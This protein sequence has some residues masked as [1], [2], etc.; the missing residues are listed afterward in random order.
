M[1]AARLAAGVRSRAGLTCPLTALEKWLLEVGGRVLYESSY[2]SHYLHD[3]LCPAW[4]RDGGLLD[5]DVHRP[6]VVGR[7]AGAMATAFDVVRTDSARFPALLAERSCP[8]RWSGPVRG[9]TAAR[10]RDRSTASL[11]GFVLRTSAVQP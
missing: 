7:R 2:I 10:D 1:V 9:G 3:V 11:T 4:A 8:H 6:R 5:R